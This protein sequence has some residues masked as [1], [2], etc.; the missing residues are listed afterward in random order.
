ME[1]ALAIFNIGVGLG[2]LASGAALVYLVWQATPLI[3]DARAVA[4]DLRR[5]TQTAD[6]ELRPIVRSAHELTT[7]VE[8]LTED[9]AVKLDRL[10]DLILALE[11]GLGR[12]YGSGSGERVPLESW[13]QQRTYR[14]DE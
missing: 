12:S 10:S 13:D 9:V 14:A 11:S 6:T 2:V 4:A 5:L 8:I 1:V 7:N 3:R